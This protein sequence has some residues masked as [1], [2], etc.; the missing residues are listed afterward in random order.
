MA[1]KD[2][3]ITFEDMDKT[4]TKELV[5][6]TTQFTSQDVKALAEIGAIKLE[7]AQEIITGMNNSPVSPEKDHCNGI[8]HKKSLI[9]MAKEKNDP[10]FTTFMQLHEQLHQLYEKFEQRYGV[11]AS[12]NQGALVGK[13]MGKLSN[14]QTQSF[15]CASKVGLFQ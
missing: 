1:N 3:T 4:L 6:S 12:T 8:L 2:V 7:D 14:G 5:L 13:L 9:L 10:D 11:E 15:E